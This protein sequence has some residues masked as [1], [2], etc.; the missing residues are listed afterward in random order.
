MREPLYLRGNIWWCRVRN[1]HGGRHAKVSTGCRDKGAAR[2]R[3]RELERLAFL[4]A[5]TAKDSP[6]L[7]RALEDRRKERKSAG[8][9][10]GTIDMMVKKGRHL[11]RL[12]GAA[13]PIAAIGAE[14]I[15][16]Y[17]STRLK[18]GAERS[19]VYKELVTLRGALKLARRRGTYPHELDKVMPEFSAKY[20]PRT[21][22]LSLKEI[23][24]LQAE[25]PPKRA[26]LVGFLV[27]TAATYPSET[28]QTRKGHI[29]L[30]RGYVHLLGTKRE[31]RD[32]KVPIVDF[33][34]PWV[35]AAI[36]FLPFEAW[37]NVG[38]DM[39]AACERA[40]IP[41]C[42]P[43]DLRRTMLTLLRAR[44]VEPSLLGVF[45]GHADSRMVERVYGRLAPE[46]LAHLLEQ[47]L[48]VP[49]LYPATRKTRTERT[50]R[51]AGKA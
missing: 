51:T 48:A 11:T 22:A 1:P 32:R 45:A 31:T 37:S 3:W 36:P 2:A 26:A 27:A 47:R 29:D 8:R 42:C 38:R 50:R 49:P 19:T 43:T 24:L 18:E 40:G 25:L 39:A 41:H 34:R 35:E 10:D 16:G 30:K 6:P 44:G 23:A 28:K 21:R 12:L 14:E 33:A 9:A 17:V 7:G 46:Q 20:K 15:D 13:T 5:D 4:P